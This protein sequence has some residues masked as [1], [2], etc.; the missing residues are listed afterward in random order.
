M[1][2]ISSG[3]LGVIQE[4]WAQ[5]LPCAQVLAFGSRVKGWPFGRPTKPYSDLD[6]AFVLLPYDLVA[7]AN[8]RADLEESNLPWRVDIT[9]LADLP[10]ALQQAVLQHG[11]WI[12]GDQAT[13]LHHTVAVEGLTRGDLALPPRA[14]A[15]SRPNHA[16]ASST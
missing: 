11:V 3:Q 1:L 7:L 4:A 9:A 2:D 15:T 6:L 5:R 16:S 12:Q 8:L 10:Q 13:L 14:R